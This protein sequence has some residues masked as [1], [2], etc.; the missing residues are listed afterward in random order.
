MSAASPTDASLRP[1]NPREGTPPPRTSSN[2]RCLRHVATADGASLITPYGTS[3]S[4][5]TLTAIYCRRRLLYGSRILPLFCSALCA[6]QAPSQC[7]PMQ[8][9]SRTSNNSPKIGEI[10]FVINRPTFLSRPDFVNGTPILR[11]ILPFAADMPVARRHENEV[12]YVL[13]LPNNRS[14]SHG[15][16]SYSSQEDIRTRISLDRSNA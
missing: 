1:R 6:T 15:L 9:P 12:P 16:C 14:P 13:R 4:R 11:D 8:C 10:Y 2:A 5:A 7:P 3:A